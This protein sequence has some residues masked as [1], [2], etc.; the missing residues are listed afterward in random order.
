VFPDV[1]SLT[2]DLR[3]V[4]INA[5]EKKTSPRGTILELFGQI[6]IVF[7]EHVLELKYMIQGKEFGTSIGSYI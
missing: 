7:H 6:S 5:F 4:P 1:C 3:T 2:I